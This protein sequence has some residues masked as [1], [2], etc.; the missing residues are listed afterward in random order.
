[1]IQLRSLHYLVALS[2]RLNFARTAEDL[3]ISQP[4]LSRSIQSLEKHLGMRLFD[5]DR[6]GVALTPQGRLAVERAIVLL[7]DADDFERQL[8]LSASAEVGRVRFGMAPMPARALLPAL[9]SER[10][11]TAPNV[12]NEVIVRDADALWA[13]L[14]AGDIEF[15]VINEGFVFESP[16]PRVETLGHFPIGSFVRAG[17]PLLHGDCEGARFP[18]LR[19]TWTGLPLPP[20]IQDRMLGHPNVIEDFGALAAI[21]ATSDAIWFSSTYAVAE[22][23]RTGQLR[24]L[25]HA[26]DASHNVRIMMYSLERRSQSPWTRSLKTMLRHHIRMLAKTDR[27]APTSVR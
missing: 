18:V 14:V 7:A 6:A 19:S 4:A 11:R 9:V 13:Q 21:T 24:E 15:F 1:M 8:V 25:P 12:T 22:E 20:E 23:L 27:T 26:K 10:L 3:G 2:R 16:P 17:H 5:R